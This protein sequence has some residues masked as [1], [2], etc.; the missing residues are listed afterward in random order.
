MSDAM[1]NRVDDLAKYQLFP[2]LPDGLNESIVSS[3][4]EEQLDTYLA[5][6]SRLLVGY[7]WQNEPFHL[8]PCSKSGKSLTNLML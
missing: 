8:R 4:L 6:L 1:Q 5:H 2:L 7:I 3:Y